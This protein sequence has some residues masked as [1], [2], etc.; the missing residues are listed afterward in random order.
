M[1]TEHTSHTQ[2]KPYTAT[3]TAQNGQLP[4]EAELWN[5]DAAIDVGQNLRGHP[6]FFIPKHDDHLAGE[7]KLMQLDAICRLL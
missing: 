1:N 2:C 5:L 4:N 6:A 3:R 7:L